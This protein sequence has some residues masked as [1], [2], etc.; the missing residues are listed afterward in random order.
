MDDELEAL[1]ARVARLEQR[2]DHVLE[3]AD[4]I[5]SDVNSARDLVDGFFMPLLLRLGTEGHR[6]KMLRWLDALLQ[7][8]KQWIEDEG[9]QN[10]DA[11]RLQ[12][13]RDLVRKREPWPDF[14]PDGWSHPREA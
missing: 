2:A 13:W 5:D 11:L 8:E 3:L 4:R 6:E 14:P 12:Y 10:R 9:K 1:R 7:V